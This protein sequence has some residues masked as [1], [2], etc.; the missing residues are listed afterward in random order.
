MMMRIWLRYSG[1]AIAV[2]AAGCSSHLRRRAIVMP[3]PSPVHQLL[4]SNSCSE[5]EA[6]RK[7]TPEREKELLKKVYDKSR[8][9]NQLLRSDANLKTAKL[10]IT[11]HTDLNCRN[12]G[13]PETFIEITGAYEL[14]ASASQKS[15]ADKFAQTYSDSQI[16][17]YNNIG[18]TRQ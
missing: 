8:L 18:K 16:P 5:V 11:A 3:T 1:S 17:V 15:I 6:Q 9:I 4:F 12:P 10:V 14:S 13:M 7:L 2:G